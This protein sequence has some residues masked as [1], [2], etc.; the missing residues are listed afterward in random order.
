MTAWMES[1]DP[2]QLSQQAAMLQTYKGLDVSLALT[3]LDMYSGP[4]R[5]VVLQE[6]T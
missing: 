3:G 1:S 5:Q 4:T 2:V 6:E